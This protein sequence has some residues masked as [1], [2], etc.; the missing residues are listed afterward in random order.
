MATNPRQQI[1]AAIG[2]MNQDDS[3][4][5][6]TRQY[7]GRNAFAEGDYKYLLNARVGN[8]KSGNDGDVETIK[9]TTE[10]TSYK[11]KVQ[12]F[13]N[14]DFVGTLDPWQT[15][16]VNT[17]EWTTLSIFGF[18]YPEVPTGCD[19]I[20]YQPVSLQAGETYPFTLQMLNHG[21]PVLE[22]L[23]IYVKFLQG[24]T[25]LSS[26]LVYSLGDGIGTT[27]QITI[28]A[29][30][31]GIG[32]QCVSTASIASVIII[33][34]L[35]LFG[36]GTASRP[37]G[38][39]KVIGKYENKEQRR[40]YYAVYNDAGNHCIRYYD[41][42]EDAV[43]ELLKWSGLAFTSD[44]FV[45]MAM[46][47]N[48]LCLAERSLSP[49]LIDVDTISDLFYTLDD[50]FR[51]YHISFHKWAPV[52][53]PRIKAYYDG[54]N[55]NY[56][57]FQNKVLQ[58]S[59]RYVYKGRLKSR[60]SPISVAVQTFENVSNDEVTHLIVEIPGFT[61]DEPGAATEYNYF[62][63]D[64]VKFT[65][66]VEFIEIAYRESARDVWRM[67]KRYDVFTDNTEFIFDG[68]VSNSTPIPAD[69]FFQLFD[70]V[71]FRAG[72]VEA[73]DNRFVF[74]DI[75]DEK[76]AAQVPVVTDIGVVSFDVLQTLGNF[77]N[78]GYRD[79][80]DNE[81]MYSGMSAADADILGN[82]SRI[83]NTT[84]KGRGLYK[85]GIQ[86]IAAN[87]WRSAVYTTDD[88]IYN[89]TEETGTIDKLYALTFKFSPQFR[90]PEWAVAY[91][92]MRTNCLNIDYF[93]FGTANAFE[94]VIDNAT[95]PTDLA[96]AGQE[97]RD[98][99]RQHFEGARQVTGQDFKK[100][101]TT[102]INKSIFRSIAADVRDTT[103]A[104]LSKSSRIYINVNNWYNSSK[105]V[106]DGTEN[107]P[108]NSLFYNYREGD[109]VRF[110]ASKTA[111]P[112]DE[113]KIVF[114]EEILEFTGRGIVVKKPTGV[115]W[116]PTDASGSDGVDF[117]IEVYTPK[118]PA[119]EDY[120]YHEVGEWYPVLYPGTDDREMSKRDWTFTN[121]AAITC[122]TYGDIKVFINKPFSLG[123]C[124]A[125]KKLLYYNYKTNIASNRVSNS[126]YSACMNPDVD[127]TW[128]FWE[129][130]TGRSA[131]A[132]TDFPVAAFRPTKF[133]FGGQIVEDSF[134]NQINR[135][136]EEDQKVFPSE[137]GRVRYL[138]V[139][140]NAQ[141]DSV[142]AILL[143][144]GENEAFSIYV[145]RTTLED[146]SGRTQVVLSDKVLGS[147]NILL[148][149]HGTRNPESV[150][151]EGGNVW[152]W[153]DTNGVWV[154]YGRDGLTEISKYKMRTWFRDINRM[155]IA[156]YG[157]DETPVA[158]SGYDPFNDELLT[159]NNHSVLPATFRDYASYKGCVF[160]EVENRWKWVH[161]YAPD[162]FAKLNDQLLL[163]KNGGLYKAEEND[164][165][166]TIYGAKHDVMIEP[167]FAD[168]TMKSWQVISIIATHKWSVERFLS[169][170]RGAKTKQQ[171]S[172]TLADFEE[173]EDAYYAAIKNDLNTPLV[174]YPLIN[175]NKMRSKALRALLKL[176]PTVTTL[177]LLHYVLVGEIDSPRNS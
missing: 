78:N 20:L 58:W 134:V 86:W 120:L 118:T 55:N 25:V 73:V 39:E 121:S 94:P 59:Y 150:T 125:I 2:G 31:D 166:S 105:K 168:R 27:T 57:R 172:L 152:Y 158:K 102:L 5:A 93:L 50:D 44:M 108:M 51:E 65:E 156:Q 149:G 49:R 84:F 68:E 148:G 110:M 175:G 60:W 14:P 88:W 42:T 71:P 157:T 80:E 107:N 37:N 171:S 15:I 66:A 174:D 113:Q 35:S 140:A 103:A 72:T 173:R 6:P 155:M 116:V 9:G 130:C 132:Y 126:L 30:C 70:T 21:N 91:Q 26:Q 109:R 137:Y 92:I 48:W 40:L 144:I 164:S 3:I 112:T 4:I 100:Y 122:E 142:G 38:N 101:L 97:L 165:H 10:I 29:N 75:L 23:S 98:R 17:G 41:R 161:D 19:D 62:N 138:V 45:K 96:G 128:D 106:A 124:H 7:A 89:I 33:K 34:K 90:P 154:R 63:N 61:L 151:A 16:D 77:W 95:E 81:D 12:L 11:G 99:L 43:F 53:P 79:P 69:D 24:T 139:T 52:M 119:S 133:R 83:S 169:E 177:S 135:F 56:D 153:D 13:T 143:A 46:I 147:Y 111:S 36:W 114:D 129:K 163:F 28:P 127:K 32:I 123:D 162:M 131:P 117:M 82:L 47:D 136:K 76:E 18:E 8:S 54:S 87:G 64:D 146:L 176:D 167:V 22:T 104:D 1:F 141:V 170:Y 85:L 145:N 74:A 160:N 159:Y 67:F 115:V